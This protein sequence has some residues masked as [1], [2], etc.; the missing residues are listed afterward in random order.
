VLIARSP[1]ARIV[2]PPAMAILRTVE[3]DDSPRREHSARNTPWST[4]IA[5]TRI[6]AMR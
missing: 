1:N 2:E 3:E 4:P 5:K 6:V